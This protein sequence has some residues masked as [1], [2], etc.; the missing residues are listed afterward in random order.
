MKGGKHMSALTEAIKI[1]ARLYCN[2]ELQQIEMP[3]LI[4]IATRLNITVGDARE[5]QNLI[6]K[7]L[8][9]QTER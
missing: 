8:E 7:I 3:K 1:R 6:Q 2:T 9:K 5:K 4:D